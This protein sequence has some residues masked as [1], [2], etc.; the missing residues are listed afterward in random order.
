MDKCNE[1][2]QKSD[3]KY[4]CS[5]DDYVDFCKSK[6]QHFGNNIIFTKD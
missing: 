4:L 3:S 5:H 2:I 1:K 6:W